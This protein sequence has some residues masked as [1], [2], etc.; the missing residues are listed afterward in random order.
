MAHQKR[1]TPAE[2]DKEYKKILKNPVSLSRWLALLDGVSRADEFERKHN[3]P[4]ADLDGMNLMEYVNDKAPIIE[5]A[6]YAG[7]I[8]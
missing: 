2:A 1:H 3:L 4:K 8:D 5:A 7:E 6:I